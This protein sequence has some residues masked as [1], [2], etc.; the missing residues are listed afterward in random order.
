M[1]DDNKKTPLPPRQKMPD[2]NKKS[3]FFPR[4]NIVKKKTTPDK[5]KPKPS[6]K[7][8]VNKNQ[9]TS[10]NKNPSPSKSDVTKNQKTSNNENPKPSP[11]KPDVTKIQTTPDDKN[12]LP[13][14]PY[15]VNNP[16]DKW[17][18]KSVTF[19]RVFGKWQCKMCNR[20]WDS[21]YTWVSIK[22]YE[23]GLDAPSH[24]H[25]KK[26]RAYQR[27]EPCEKKD[28]NKHEA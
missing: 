21:A 20:T 27:C 2:N 28:P 11:P 8:N 9:K 3:L 23:Q 12:T 16:L 4:T 22:M 5:E 14:R 18:N 6:P 17:R 25:N 10:D 26:E 13:P 7:P 19:G 24:F 15:I 1:A